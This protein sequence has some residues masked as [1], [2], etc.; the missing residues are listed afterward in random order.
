MFIV[1]KHHKIQ[2]FICIASGENNTNVQAA[3]LDTSCALPFYKPQ[4]CK[5]CD[6][7]H[8]KTDRW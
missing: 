6:N 4:T 2:V 5:S 3:F 8:S 7:T 1:N